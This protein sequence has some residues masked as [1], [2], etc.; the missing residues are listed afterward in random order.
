MPFCAYKQMPFGLCYA[1]ATFQRCMLAIFQDI[2]KESIEVFM[3]NFSVFGNSFDNCLNNLDKMLQRCKDASF[4]L[5]WEKCHFMVKEGI[6]LGHKVSG[7]GLEV[8]KA[9]IN[10]ISKLPPPTNVKGIRIGAL[11]GQKDGKHFH[12]I[13]FA[14]KTLNASQQNS[15]LIEKE[16]MAIVFAFDKFKAY[17]VLSKI[18]VYTDHSALRHLFKKQVAKPC[19]DDEIDDNFPSETLREISTKYIPYVELYGKDGKTFIVNGDRLKLYHEEEP[20]NDRREEL[21][22]F[23]QKNE[24]PKHECSSK[25][26]RRTREEEP[27]ILAHG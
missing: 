8:D 12:P 17:L 3:D 19:D 21:T 27:K 18:V 13:Y 1:P 5:N 26:K 24:P 11:L 2:I 4:V 22:P 7:A 6:I 10:V 9:K 16:L 25:N 14:S 23:I 15:T 20:Y